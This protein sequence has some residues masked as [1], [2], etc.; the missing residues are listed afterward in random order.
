MNLKIL[1]I[2]YRFE[3]FEIFNACKKKC[4]I[5]QINADDI[6]NN[7]NNAIE[8]FFDLEENSY[9]RII[10]YNYIKL[11]LVIDIK[12]EIVITL[13]PVDVQTIQNRRE[14]KRWI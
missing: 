10:D 13:Y 14:S 1:G 8:E 11:A 9:I 4:E 7:E 3:G 5:Y 12:R 2:Y 6:L